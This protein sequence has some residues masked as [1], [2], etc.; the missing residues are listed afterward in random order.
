VRP[1]GKILL[2]LDL[3]E[4]LVYAG[5][6][7]LS[8]PADFR[9]GPYHVYRRPHLEAFLSGCSALFDLAVWSSASPA[10]VAAVVPAILPVGVEPVLA[11][12]CRR[13][14][15]RLDPDTKEDYFVKD[16]RKVCRKGF[17]LGRVLAVDDTPRK[18]ERNYGNAVYVRPFLGDPD[19]AELPALGRYLASL[20]D[21]PDVRKLEKRGWRRQ[22]A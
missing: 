2:V 15:R 6:V 9:A 18:L 22:V 7:S 12:D 14:V 8:R 21:V 17:D 19:D 11:W 1:E 20:H 3:D 13:C 16:L 10:C 4:T 5:D